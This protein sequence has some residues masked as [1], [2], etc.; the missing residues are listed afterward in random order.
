M[1]GWAIMLAADVSTQMS[2]T[3]GYIQ[4]SVV[5]KCR[6]H[7]VALSVRTT[8]KLCEEISVVLQGVLGSL[9]P[10]RLW[11]CSALQVDVRIPYLSFFTL[12]SP[13]HP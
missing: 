8:A 1:A 2:Q 3:R 10:G 7:P 9:S 12:I 6:S 5:L 13:E 11:C 4:I